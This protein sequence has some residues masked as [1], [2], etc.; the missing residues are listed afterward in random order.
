MRMKRND[1]QPVSQLQIEAAEALAFPR[2]FPCGTSHL[3]TDRSN[4]GAAAVTVGEYA[5]QRILN[6]DPRFREDELYCAWLLGLWNFQQLSSA[7]QVQAKSNKTGQTAQQMLSPVHAPQLARHS[8]M[9]STSGR[10]PR[11][12]AAPRNTGHTTQRICMPW[13]ALWGLLPGF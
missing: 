10:S 2:H 8:T 7:V 6:E 3:R 9:M 12:F 11:T 13:F 5:K 4:T 1:N